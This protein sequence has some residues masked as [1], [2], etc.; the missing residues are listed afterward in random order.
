MGSGLRLLPLMGGLALGAGLADQVATRL[1]TKLTAA[2]GFLLL[3]GGL[4]L[5]ATMTV[6]SGD[7]FIA[8]WTAIT[9]VGFGLTLATAASAALVDLPKA[10]AGIGSAVMQA[11]QKVGAPLSAAVL[12]SV[13]TAA[14]HS[15]LHLAA[16]AAATASAARSSVFAGLAVAGRLGSATLADTVRSAFVHGIDTMLWVSAGLAAAGIGLAL[17]FLPWHAKQGAKPATATGHY[18]EGAESAHERVA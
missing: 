17:A 3:T 1:T 13:V 11:V 7:T 5:G 18:G 9:G 8:T 4:A 15:G 10:S 6:A 16:L 2:L 14:Y 12:G